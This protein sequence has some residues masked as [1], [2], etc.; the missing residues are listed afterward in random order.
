LPRRDRGAAIA[1]P[2]KQLTIA[3]RSFIVDPS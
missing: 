3:N 2:G 1:R